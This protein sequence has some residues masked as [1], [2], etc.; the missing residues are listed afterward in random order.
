[1][2]T[3]QLKR[4]VLIGFTV[5]TQVYAMNSGGLTP[6]SIDKPCSEHARVSEQSEAVKDVK[7]IQ[8]GTP[9]NYLKN[10]DGLRDQLFG[11]DESDLRKWPSVYKRI[12]VPPTDLDRYIELLAEPSGAYME[13]ARGL[14]DLRTFRRDMERWVVALKASENTKSNDRVIHKL[15]RVGILEDVVLELSDFEQ[16]QKQNSRYGRR[17]RTRDGFK[18]QEEVEVAPLSKEAASYKTDYKDYEFHPRFHEGVN[19]PEPALPSIAWEYSAARNRY[20]LNAFDLAV[21]HGHADDVGWY[22]SEHGIPLDY[23]RWERYFWTE[24]AQRI[25][26]AHRYSTKFRFA[27]AGI[28]T[29]MHLAVVSDNDPENQILKMLI[30]NQT[31][32]KDWKR[33]DAERHSG[34]WT[35]M[36]EP[37]G[38]LHVND[39]DVMGL[40]PLHYA[41]LLDK[42][43]AV[44]MLLDA[45]AN[46]KEKVG[47]TKLNAVELA[48]LSGSSSV[49]EELLVGFK[50]PPEDFDERLV[51]GRNI[52]HHA[53][54]NGDSSS[55]QAILGGIIAVDAETVSIEHRTA[56]HFAAM[57]GNA[58][59]V[60]ELISVGVDVSARDSCGREALHYAAISGSEAVV[61]LLMNNGADANLRDKHGKSAK[62]LA[63]SSG[64]SGLLKSME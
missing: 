2:K 27:I 17:I 25:D 6:S 14:I 31:E 24:M 59:I 49:L 44:R 22:M 63:Q 8:P 45:G 41:I 42:P 35:N 58:P 37:A 62:A 32:L 39:R 51:A 33:K 48:V 36:S 9:N 55:V 3:I 16:K 13:D 53:A 18:T 1:M 26:P 43:A 12:A 47:N 57:N 15:A 64:H 10:P 56:L 61:Q 60:D 54:L 40:T 50:S 11:N 34:P 19:D 20:G 38:I 29:P 21:L 7:G 52:L 5:T 28:T 4:A 46:L 30:D 23:A